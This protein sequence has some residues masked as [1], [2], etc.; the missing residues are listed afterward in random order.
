MR[1][2]VLALVVLC[3][4]PSSAVAAPEPWDGTNPFVCEV[5]QAGFGTAVPDPGADP[6]CVEFDKRR[7][8][9]TQLGVV[10]FLAQEPA[11]VA[12]TNDKCFYFQ[13]DHWRGSVVQDDGS[14]KTYEW[15]GH[16]FYDKARA[17]GGAWITNF[18][19]NGRTGD[20]ST[21]PGMPAEYAQFFGPGTGGVRE[22][23]SGVEP[24]AE[25]AE[26][27]RREPE[28]IYA[29]SAGG[30]GAGSG[31]GA[32]G[33][34]LAY[35]TD[36]KRC[37]TPRTGRARSRR[38]GAVRLGWSERR[39]RSVLG[40]PAEVRRGFLRYC[41][42]PAFLV[43]Q[44]ED[45]SGDMGSGDGERTVMVVARRGGFRVGRKR[46]GSWLRRARPF[47]RAVRVARVGRYRVFATRRRSGVLVGV[48]RKR[49]RFIAVYDRRVIRSRAR[50]KA[51]LRR[52]LAG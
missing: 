47:P 1:L 39:V 52:A 18:S 33:G 20:P 34:R 49:V 28:R 29:A 12:A 19:V 32:A 21:L 40:V 50:V 16:Y 30:G 43:G 17:E 15:D 46:L 5:Q 22:V 11:R 37:R 36:P 41:S 31:A 25:C 48:H 7:Q 9:V 13:I 10:D 23:G 44:R 38:L 6:Y 4:V 8:N 26:R 45:R 24:S 27:A 51:Y 42:R 14:T 35:G 2:S 3:V